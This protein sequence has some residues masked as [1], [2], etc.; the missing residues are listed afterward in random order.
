MKSRNGNMVN[1]LFDK[2]SPPKIPLV[3]FP[4][5]VSL[6]GVFGVTSETTSGFFN[7]FDLGIIIFFQR[8]VIWH[9]EILGSIQFR[10][11]KGLVVCW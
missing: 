9:S 8:H 10:L 2:K 7:V 6:A 3:V 11:L 5:R 4:K 1:V